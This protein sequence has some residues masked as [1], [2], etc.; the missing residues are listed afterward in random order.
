MSA[1]TASQEI[2]SYTA[3]APA[4][5]DITIFGDI[6]D[7]NLIKRGTLQQ[8]IELYNDLLATMS[9]KTFV[10]PAL[11]TPAS[12]V[13]TNATGLPLTTGVTGTLP[14]ANGGTANTTAQA[15]ID[16]LSNVAAATDEHVLTK[17]TASGN[18]IWKASSGG[19]VTTWTADHDTGGN[20]LVLTDDAAAPTATTNHFITHT[21]TF[22]QYNVIAAHTHVFTI[23][24]ATEFSIS[25]GTID[26]RDNDILDAGDINTAGNISTGTLESIAIGDYALATGDIFTGTHDFSGAT[27]EIPNS[28]TATVAADGQIAFDNLVTDWSTGILRVFGSGEEQGV[29]TMPIAQFTTPTDNHVVTYN[30][31]NDEF[32][33][34]P[35]GGGASALNDLSDVTITG[36]LQDADLLLYDSVGTAYKDVPMTG[37]VTITKAGVT[38]VADD[39][40]AHTNSSITLAATDLSDTADLAFLNTANTWG[41]FNQDLTSATMRIPSAAAPTMATLGD[42]AIDTTITDFSMGLIKYYDVEEMAVV[43]MPVAQ[44]TT[45]TEGHVV[46]YNATTDE[47]ELRVAPGA[48]GG[49]TS[50]NSQTGS[51]QTMTQ[52]TNKILINSATDDHAFTLGTDVVTIDKANT[53]EDFLQTFKDNQL[54]I[55]SPDD[56]DGVTF[57]NSNQTADRNLTIPV[58]TG[59]RNIVVTAEASQITIGTEVTGASTA[60]TDAA[61][62]AYLNTANIFIAGNKQTFS[63]DVTTAGLNLGAV[64][65]APSTPA[66]GDVWYAG[67]DDTLNFRDAAATRTIATLDNN[68]TLTNKTLTQPTIGDLVNANHTHTNAAGGGQIAASTAL[69]DY[70]DLAKVAGDVY[71]GV[72]DF[73]TGGTVLEIP[74]EAAPTVNANGEIAIDTSVT[75]FSLSVL[76]FFGGEEQGVVSMPIAEFTTPAAGAVPTYNATNDEFEMVVPAGS[77]DMVL[78]DVQTVTGA[79]TFGTIGGAVGKFILA[80][81]T[82]GSTIVDASAVASGTITI[83]AA[84]DTLMGKATTDTM[85]N[86]TFDANGTGN[87]ITNIE[88]ADIAAAAAIDVTKLSNDAR[89]G[90]LTFVI[91]GGGS[92]IT[93]GKKGVLVVDYD[94]T[95]TGWTVV[96]EPDGAIVVDVNRST[97]AGY[98][99]TASIA[100]TELPTVTA[101]NDTGQDYSL[102]SWS[103][104]NAGDIIEFEVDSITTATRATVSLRTLKT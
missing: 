25:N 12:G 23:N 76:K 83:P 4:L 44:L 49:I 60:L 96:C 65:A 67:V 27:L 55:N 34:Q 28:D 18:A 9:N 54:K 7:S 38:T 62:L 94:C 91:D 75:D 5:G 58:L 47:F 80:G 43:A 79:K 85:T 26:F 63:Q 3:V 17:D 74:N 70:N 1:P 68:Q 90:N 81:S 78:A 97:F 32:E 39:S 56:L 88:N 98:P 33:L 71:T 102:T 86:K 16:A 41:A 101:T 48:G 57:V 99:T 69:S 51:V 6:T 64:S 24:G 52:Q 42:F 29:V 15:A 8:V 66:E 37:D 61:D 95:V 21:S 14:I 72:H 103:T 36:P 35:G 59:N 89:L 53:Y 11:G 20:A 22:N 104:I 40:H 30:A 13:L 84:T 73:G 77:G 82:S 19:E 2:D 87:S 31:T 10:A 45:P 46:T 100:G 93:T 92:A 50:I